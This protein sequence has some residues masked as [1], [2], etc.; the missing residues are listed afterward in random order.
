MLLGGWRNNQYLGR[1]ILPTCPLSRERFTVQRII[2]I[3][4]CPSPKKLPTNLHGRRWM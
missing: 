4:R 1:N 2:V 3:R